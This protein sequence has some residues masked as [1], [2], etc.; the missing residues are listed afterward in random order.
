MSLAFRAMNRLGLNQSQFGQFYIVVAYRHL[1]NGHFQQV[2]DNLQ[3]GME[4]HRMFG[5]NH[6]LRECLN[7]RGWIELTIGLQQS[8]AESFR[9]LYDLADVDLDNYGKM[10]ALLGT[11]ANLAQEGRHDQASEY[12]DRAAAV[13]DVTNAHQL[14]FALGFRAH[15]NLR[16]GYE[17]GALDVA[18]R[19]ISKL[20]APTAAAAPHNVLPLHKLLDVHLTLLEQY[21]GND[22]PHA[23]AVI[24]RCV[25]GINE[26]LTL[27]RQFIVRIPLMRCGLHICEGRFA[28]LYQNQNERAEAL[29]KRAVH[30]SREANLKPMEGAACF[31]LGRILPE[32]SADRKMYLEA[33]AAIFK[34]VQ[35]KYDEQLAIAELASKGASRIFKMRAE[36]V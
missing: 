9:Q 10:W 3:R 2:F 30:M 36:D 16:E 34:A 35:A 14:M 27:Y 5:Q 17:E 29:L 25:E 7:A 11:A 8:S 28:A 22:S 12:L 31:E 13:E 19:T 18:E 6:Q 23:K 20:K 33:A 26:E 1:L 4:M 24:K 32:G 15:I 21:Q